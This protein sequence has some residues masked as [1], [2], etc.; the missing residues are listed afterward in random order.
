MR[1]VSGGCKG[2]EESEMRLMILRT[3]GTDFAKVEEC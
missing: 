1:Y 3:C 2:G